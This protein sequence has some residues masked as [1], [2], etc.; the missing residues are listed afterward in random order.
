LIKVALIGPPLSG[1]TTVFKALTAGHSQTAKSQAGHVEIHRGVVK[2]PDPKLHKLAEMYQ[3]KKVSEV[4]IEYFDLVGTLESEKK[5]EGEKTAILRESDELALVCG[6]FQDYS[7]QN[8]VTLQ[9]EIE[10]VLEDL[11]LLDYILVEK[12]LERMK[13][14]TKGPATPQSKQEQELLEKCRKA[15]E[16]QVPCRKLEFTSEEEKLL[17]SYA[18]LTAKPVLT[19]LNLGEKEIP[20][21][22]EIEKKFEDFA[23]EKDSLGIAVCGEMESELSQLSEAERGD[24]MQDLGIEK[25][26]SHRVATGSYQ[27]M[28]LISF[29]T[30]NQNEVRAWAIPRGYKAIQAAGTVHTDM[31]KGFIK[32]EV[33]NIDRLFQLGSMHAAKE[34]GEV[35]LHGKEYLVQD[36]DVIFFRFNV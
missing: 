17:R 36:G 19:I 35:G 16:K 5:Q 25:P 28:N 9:K 12:R 33:I 30:A 29:Y 27:L 32:A 34:K 3:P 14:Q 31:E 8:L 6:L 10:K 24:F 13:K 2:V 26:S 15:L 11:I 23:K 18:L 22:A 20:K 4:E 1:K 21:T 7:G